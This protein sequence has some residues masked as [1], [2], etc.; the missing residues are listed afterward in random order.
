[1]NTFSG[2]KIPYP[3]DTTEVASGHQC[4]IALEVDT[5][6][7]SRVS[8]LCNTIGG[9]QLSPDSASTDID[10]KHKLGLFCAFTSRSARFEVRGESNDKRDIEQD[11]HMHRRIQSA[12]AVGARNAQADL[13]EQLLPSLNIPQPPRVVE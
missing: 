4:S 12:H 2:A 1:M 10:N 13:E 3:A 5:V 7:F 6:R 11:T 9:G 8:L